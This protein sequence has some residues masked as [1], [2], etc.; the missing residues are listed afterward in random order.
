MLKK[1]FEAVFVLF[2]MVPATLA[3]LFVIGA[4]ETVPRPFLNR[5]GH[6]LARVYEFAF[7][8]S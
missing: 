8:R 6:R 3:A 1:I 2:L 7:L 4:L 5:I